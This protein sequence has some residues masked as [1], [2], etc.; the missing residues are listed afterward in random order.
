MNLVS[1]TTE[2]R[3][4]RKTTHLYA[5]RIRVVKLLV[6]RHLEARLDRILVKELFEPR[7]GAGRRDGRGRRS[8]GEAVLVDPEEDEFVEDHEAVALI[9]RERVVR[10][11][12]HDGLEDVLQRVLVLCGTGSRRSVLVEVRGRKDGRR[13]GRVEHLLQVRSTNREDE[14]KV[15]ATKRRVLNHVVCS[16]DRQCE[17][18]E[19]AVEDGK[20]EGV[21]DVEEGDLRS[22]RP[23]ALREE[24]EEERKDE[25]CTWRREDRGS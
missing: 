21:E 9:R 10:D 19:N 12:V 1:A 4:R 23:S 16:G 20:E 5:L 22:Q 15:G 24:A 25:P 14:V 18:V 8:G 11:V 13:T 3:R 6:H 2:K 7:N 17:E